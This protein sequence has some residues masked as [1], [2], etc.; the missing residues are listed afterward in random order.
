LVVV[1]TYLRMYLFP[2]G[3]NVDHYQMLYTLPYQWPVILSGVIIIFM[4]VG[5]Y[6]MY[7]QHSADKRYTLLFVGVCWYFLGLAVS[8]SVIPLPDLMAEHRAY[9]SSIG[10]I[11]ALVCSLDLIRASFGSAKSSKMMVALV[12]VWCVILMVLTF[13]RNKVWEDGILLWSNSVKNNPASHRA[14]YNLGV[15]YVTAKAYTESLRY[16]NKSMEISPDWPQ[17]YEVLAVAL[18]ELKRYQE[19]IDVSLRGIAVAPTEPVLYNNLGIAYAESDREEDARQ[20]FSTALALSPGYENAISNLKRI[21]S[22]L[23]S[24]VGKRS[25]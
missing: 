17:A 23:E 13:N 5:T 25:W 6:F 21:E 12:T 20:A 9:F 11:L 8:S 14:N 18:I 1:L 16:L 10:L 24:N 15:A 22:F 7:R 3:Q 19:A 2:Y 4:V